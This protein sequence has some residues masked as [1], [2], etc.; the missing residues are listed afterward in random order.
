[1]EMCNNEVDFLKDPAGYLFSI[2]MVKIQ[3]VSPLCLCRIGKRVFF[4]DNTHFFF[5]I[6]S[7]MFHLPSSV[8]SKSRILAAVICNPKNENT[9]NLSSTYRIGKNDKGSIKPIIPNS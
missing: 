5:D 3:H 4:V 2:Y 6:C 7:C 9:T 8:A 1:M